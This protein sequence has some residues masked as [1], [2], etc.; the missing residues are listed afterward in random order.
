MN[1]AN[2]E[3]DVI[4]PP[5]KKRVKRF[6]SATEEE[7]KVASRNVM[8][9][10]MENNDRWALNNFE[11]RRKAHNE[12]HSD[13][14]CSSD[15]LLTG[16]ASQPDSWLVRYVRRWLY[17]SSKKYRILASWASAIHAGS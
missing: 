5:E 2:A 10:K 12:A 9:K 16:D 11:L 17:V 7:L 6:Y 1:P 15:I 13:L 4:Q 14:Q 3:S 8:P